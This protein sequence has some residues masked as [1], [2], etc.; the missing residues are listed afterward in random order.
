MRNG[1]LTTGKNTCNSRPVDILGVQFVPGT[2]C[3]YC[4]NFCVDPPTQLKPASSAGQ[5][6][7]VLLISSYCPSLILSWE[8]RRIG[9]T[10]RSTKG[11]RATGPAMVMRYSKFPTR[12]KSP[13]GKTIWSKG[14]GMVYA[15]C[16]GL[17]GFLGTIEPS[18]LRNW[19]EVVFG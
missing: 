10:P 14:T 1:A 19:I 5:P 8:S 3:R 2:G 9:S 17:A 15:P 11:A 7:T 12:L 13:P 6:K 4:G 16:R 18:G